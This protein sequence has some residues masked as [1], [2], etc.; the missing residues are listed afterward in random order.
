M[1]TVNFSK[2]YAL[3]VD[4]DHYSTDIL[5]QIFRGFGLTQFQ[6]VD[7]VAAA[8]EFIEKVEIDLLICEASLPDGT[9]IDL[10][11]WM[12]HLPSVPLK[13]TPVVMLTSYTH[14]ANVVG[15]RDAGANTVVRKP[16]SPKVL[17][18]HIMWAAAQERPFIETDVFVGPDRRFKFTGPPDGVGRRQGDVPLEIGEAKEP[19][20]SQEELNSAF[21]PT[22]M[23]IE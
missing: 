10:V 12:R 9:G 23:T 6:V 21:K 7:T 2:I 5:G 15:A 19:N 17:L 13:S 11:N 4:D 22:R 3:V 8:R 1:S 14:M 18:N 16:V 20:M